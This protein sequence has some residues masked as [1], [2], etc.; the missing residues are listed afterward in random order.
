MYFSA[1]LLAAA[2]SESLFFLKMSFWYGAFIILGVGTAVQALWAKRIK[3][4]WLKRR[5][6]TWFI[7]GR[8]E[9]PGSPGSGI[10]PASERLG[11][12]E[13]DLKEQHQ[14]I[15]NQG[16]DII[17]IKGL[18]VD[19]ND[20]LARALTLAANTNLKVTAN[21]GNTDSAPDTLQRIARKMGVWDHDGQPP[22]SVA[23]IVELHDILAS[24]QT[25]SAEA[26]VTVAPHH[27]DGLQGGEVSEQQS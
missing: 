8:P 18:L 27:H 25:A 2:K 6:F 12:V 7:V 5:N 13:Q 15:K 26:D 19:V 11:N 1:P 20:K 10:L 22:I 4:W 9:A 3:A 17:E 14:D 21:G 24:I 16:S 23:N